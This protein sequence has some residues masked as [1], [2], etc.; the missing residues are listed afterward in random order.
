MKGI[1]LLP[2]LVAALAPGF[3]DATPF[4]TDATFSIPATDAIAT[5]TIPSLWNPTSN[6]GGVQAVSPRSPPMNLA[7]GQFEAMDAQAAIQEVIHNFRPKGVLVDASSATTTQTTI[8][9]LTAYNVSLNG[10]YN[11]ALGYFG[12]TVVATNAKGKFVMLFYW[13]ESGSQEDN[14]SDMQS[15]NNSVRATK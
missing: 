14:A 2:F 6:S 5:V 11:G 9:N 4:S 7:V 8:N 12:L 15:I 10:T 1:F 13:G 3:A